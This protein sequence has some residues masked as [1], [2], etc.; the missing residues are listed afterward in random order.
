MVP[1]EDREWFAQT[2]P[3]G[4]KQGQFSAPLSWRAA[5]AAL[6]IVDKAKA[7]TVEPKA[8]N[9]NKLGTQ[10]LILA[11]AIH[12]GFGTPV[13]NDNSQIEQTLNLTYINAADYNWRCCRGGHA[14]Y[15]ISTCG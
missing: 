1:S 4:M 7:Q 5:H 15:T 8:L 2:G 3:F 6:A 10:D 12:L 13:T 14:S 9:V 11:A